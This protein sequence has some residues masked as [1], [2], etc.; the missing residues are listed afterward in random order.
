MAELWEARRR[1]KFQ[2]GIEG[3]ECRREGIENLLNKI[4]G[5]IPPNSDKEMS[6]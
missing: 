5:E 3:E 1:S 2:M 6:I 4:L